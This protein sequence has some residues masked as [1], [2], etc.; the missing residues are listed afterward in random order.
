MNF[1]QAFAGADD[2]VLEVEEIA[3]ATLATADR[4]GLALDRRPPRSALKALTAMHRALT[5][6]AAI[7][8]DRLADAVALKD[9]YTIWVFAVDD[10]IDHDGSLAELR[11]SVLVLVGAGSG[12]A[13]P[14]GAIL[15]ELLRRARESG[16][17]VPLAAALSE[18]ISGLHYEHAR[19]G[20][21]GLAEP[22]R[23]MRQNIAIS[24]F[25]PFLA[26]DAL[27]AAPG[28]LTDRSLVVASRT[29]HE[30]SSAMR[31]A[32][33]VGGVERERRDRTATVIDL[34]LDGEAEGDEQRL[35]DIAAER[36]RDHVA[37]ARS[38]SATADV[39]GLA[40][41]VEAMDRLT[42]MCVADDVFGAQA[43]Q[44]LS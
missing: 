38:H 12:P 26:I 23:Y 16:D 28:R 37:R 17:T 40:E 15:G 1:L 42:A 24:S 20:H 41:V 19:R 2:A 27:H 31:Y 9:L 14:A 8:P 5:L 7:E 43:R 4:L 29:L 33:E 44:F 13:T 39:P 11:D 10:A 35:R 30:L 6:R 18:V 32:L 25:E 36:V 22:G 21:P 34:W 3:A